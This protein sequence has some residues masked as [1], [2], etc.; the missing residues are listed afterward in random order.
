MPSVTSNFIFS[1]FKSFHT[2]RNI[3][4]SNQCGLGSLI[5]GSWVYGLKEGPSLS[6][7]CSSSQWCWS[8]WH[9]CMV[10][11]VCWSQW[12]ANFE[13]QISDWA[14]ALLSIKMVMRIV[15]IIIN[16]KMAGK[17]F[18]KMATRMIIVI[19][20]LSKCLWRMKWV[21]ENVYIPWF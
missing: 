15:V 3:N 17:I 20:L 11:A 13:P 1:M 7:S 19:N 21:H 4:I 14:S 2:Y 12:G 10:W 18:I 5:L 16:I 8:V 9:Q 6:C